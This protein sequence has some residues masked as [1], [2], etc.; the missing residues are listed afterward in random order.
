MSKKKNTIPFDWAQKTARDMLFDIMPYCERN[1]CEVV[2]SVR[3]EAP[4]RRRHRVS[5]CPDPALRS[6]PVWNHDPVR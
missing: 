5:I 3:R 2:G 4:E 1:Y 6:R